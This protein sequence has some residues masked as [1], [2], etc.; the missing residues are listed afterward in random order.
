MKEQCLP[1]LVNQIVKVADITK[2]EK[3]ES[4]FC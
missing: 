2:A 4:I 1:C 3:L